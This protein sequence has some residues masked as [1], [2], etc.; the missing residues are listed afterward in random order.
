MNPVWRK[1]WLTWRV[2]SFRALRSRLAWKVRTANR[3]SVTTLSVSSIKASCKGVNTMGECLFPQIGFTYRIILEQIGGGV[4]KYYAP[5]FQDIASMRD[6]K[7]LVCVL[8][9]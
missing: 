7:R 3:L 1:A 2:A 4:G 6:T 5:G 8:L 9:D